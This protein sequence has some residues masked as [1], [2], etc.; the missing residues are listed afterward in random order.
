MANFRIRPLTVLLVFGAVALVAISVVY[1][2]QTA[3]KLPGFFPGHAAG[4]T[5]HHIKHGIA[6]DILA[7]L[8]LGAAWFTTA[9]DRPSD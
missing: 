9:P 3:D 6:F 5:K 7:L 1:Y 4:S 8:A 2:T